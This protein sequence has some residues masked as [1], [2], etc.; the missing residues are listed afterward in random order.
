MSRKTQMVYGR[1]V[2]RKAK[3][4][5]DTDLHTQHRTRLLTAGGRL[6]SC[7]YCSIYHTNGL[8]PSTPQHSPRDTLGW[9]ETEIGK[10]CEEEWNEEKNEEKIGDN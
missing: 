10:P 8:V 9:P 2:V 1:R 4:D 7:R 3:V 6:V 5:P